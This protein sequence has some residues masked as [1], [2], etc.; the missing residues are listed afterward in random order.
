MDKKSIGITVFGVLFL[1]LALRGIHS[2]IR[3]W[4]LIG[5]QVSTYIP[6]LANIALSIGALRRTRWFP[7]LL[8]VYTVIVFFGLVYFAYY[9][10]SY[11]PNSLTKLLIMGIVNILPYPIAT[12]YFTRRN[13]K[14]MFK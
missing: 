1:L 11:S 7:K 14:E 3:Y 2:T 13:V 9:V 10:W 8:Y 5:R 4:S 12:Y 6:I